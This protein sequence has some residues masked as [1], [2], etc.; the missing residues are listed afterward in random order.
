MRLPFLST[1]EAIVEG[2]PRRLSEL[3]EPDEGGAPRPSQPAPSEGPPSPL[4]LHAA[5]LLQKLPRPQPLSPSAMGRIGAA[6]VAPPRSRP[7]LYLAPAAAALALVVGTLGPSLWRRGAGPDGLAL[8]ELRLPDGGQARLEGASGGAVLA[9]G[10]AVL[11]RDGASLILD[12]GRLL[13][14][15]GATELTVRGGRSTVTL[16]PRRAAEVV[17]HLGQLVRVAAYVGDSAVRPEAHEGR[18]ITVREGTAWTAAGVL[19]VP[20][21]CRSLPERAWL[22]GAGPLP[23]CVPEAVAAAT[24]PVAP[25]PAAIEPPGLPAPAAAPEAAPVVAKPP[26]PT[27]APGRV[28]IARPVPVENASP[29]SLLAEESRLLGAALRQLRQERD[30]AAALRTLD[31]YRTRFPGGALI[32]EAQAARVDVLLQ[33]ERRAEALTVLEQ[34]R[35]QRL[36][37][38]GELLALRGEL[39]AAAGRCREADGDFQAAL[40]GRPTPQVTERAL[41]GRASCLARLGDREGAQR[42]LR[43]ITESFPGGRY[44]EPAR[45][46]LSTLESTR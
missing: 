10:P 11:R 46:A 17:V 23:G 3:Q 41:Y 37:R 36:P 7:W 22:P 19:P 39:R 13:V 40:A 6:L 38:G 45:R 12:E 33:L 9:L 28:I 1:P 5:A 42:L 21:E 14:R 24:P 44:A 18:E 35:F 29:A 16:L 2:P 8:R 25:P 34:T 32:E 4:E 43:Q 30:A 20:P 27:R 26:R 15:A 31:Q